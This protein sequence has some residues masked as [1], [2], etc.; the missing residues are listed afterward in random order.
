MRCLAYSS[1]FQLTRQRSAAS[2]PRILKGACRIGAAG[3][4]ADYLGSC[5]RII[6]Y[7]R[8]AAAS[9]TLR[10]DFPGRHR[11]QGSDSPVIGWLFG[12]GSRGCWRL[13]L[14]RCFA[15]QSRFRVRLFG[16]DQG[17]IGR[18]VRHRGIFNE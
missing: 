15:V 12:E 2:V 16:I 5:T 17:S 10:A 4:W 6:Q 9:H 18:V 11:W 14:Q 7:G 13:S 3:R 1:V 8:T